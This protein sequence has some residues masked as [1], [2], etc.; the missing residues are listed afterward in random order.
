MADLDLG[1]PIQLNPK[2]KKDDSGP[3]A[4]AGTPIATADPASSTD[5]SK[6]GDDAP[7]PKT[8]M[9]P[10]GFDATGGPPKPIM[11]SGGDTS[12]DITMPD[13]T[14]KGIGGIKL[15]GMFGGKKEGGPVAP[16][17][18]ESLEKSGDAS[19]GMKMPAGITPSKGGI[20]PPGI[21]PEPGKS[22]L[23]LPGGSGGGLLANKKVIIAVGAV[24]GVIVLLLVGYLIYSSVSGEDD[25]SSDL[26]PET[27]TNGDT[28]PEDDELP[29]YGDEDGDGLQN[30]L[31]EQ[32]NADPT[33][34]D[35]DGDGY[36]DGQEV[37][38]GFDPAGPGNLSTGGRF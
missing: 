3:E 21:N 2:G 13:E 8:S 15:P 6:P 17:L 14:K 27:S 32:Y 20:V 1:D 28:D 31:E 16:K 11:P 5:P 4:G 35:T 33:N 7:D 19:D 30:Y 12:G 26:E 18:P 22:P 38:G 36:T 25:S 34:P 10:P 37:D 23:P 9:D 29:P 24:I